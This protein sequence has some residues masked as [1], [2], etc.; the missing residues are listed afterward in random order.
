MFRPQF[1]GEAVRSMHGMPD[2]ALDILV[3]VMVAVCEDPYDRLHSA[4]LLDSNPDVRLAE[5][6]DFGFIEF[7]VDASAELIFVHTFVW[8]A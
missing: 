2:E 6:G 5:L 8:A 3:S 1:D 4:P 7:R